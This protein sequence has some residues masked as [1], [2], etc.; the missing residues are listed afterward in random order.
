MLIEMSIFGAV[1]LGVAGG[2]M[3]DKIRVHID[4]PAPARS[5][6]GL[7][8]YSP[9]PRASGPVKRMPT[10]P[11]TALAPAH[12]G[13]MDSVTQ[14]RLVSDA[15]FS[16]RRI[17][18]EEAAALLGEVESIVAELGQK[19]RVMSQVSLSDIVDSADTE[20]LSAI[21]NQRVDLAITTARQMPIAVIEYQAMGQIRQDDAIQD[22][23]RR[24]ALRRAG[25]I[26]IQVRASDPAGVLRDQLARL[27]AFQGMA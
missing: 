20:A 24:E 8:L 18:S 11:S 25:I 5:G 12:S 26:Y 14:L 2:F 27:A 23:V 10:M 9:E 13:P 17:L 19:W 7:Q 4:G 22:A 3:L 6:T 15:R 16:S 21:G 1:I